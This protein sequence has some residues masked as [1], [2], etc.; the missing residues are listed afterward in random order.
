MSELE[1]TVSSLRRAR[2]GL[3][4][5]R[6]AAD[7]AGGGGV[8]ES[9]SGDTRRSRRISSTRRREMDAEYSRIDAEYRRI[10]ARIQDPV[11]VPPLNADLPTST[12]GI[13]RRDMEA[14]RRLA[15][16]RECAPRNAPMVPSGATPPQ[17]LPATNLG[18]IRNQKAP[19]VVRSTA[20]SPASFA[21][22][23]TGALVDGDDEDTRG[24]L[25][26][27]EPTS[28]DR[29][30]RRARPVRAELLNLRA[31][32]EN[33]QAETQ[34]LMDMIQQVDS[35]QQR[36]ASRPPGTSSTVD[37]DA[38]APVAEQSVQETLRRERVAR[39]RARADQIRGDD[40]EG[41]SVE[42]QAASAPQARRPAFEIAPY[43][44]AA[45]QARRRWGM[46]QPD[47]LSRGEIGSDDDTPSR[48]RRRNR[49]V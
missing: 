45:W 41:T 40:P 31:E 13:L 24:P 12:D 18:V 30:Q 35:N 19:I 3:E 33:A 32:M 25:G 16:I 28:S 5:G 21:P 27:G 10:R 14:R 9:G 1:G 22:S 8:A 44:G 20:P 15:M 23:S 7:S 47:R 26:A 34:A 17:G 39:I 48:R 46:H 49:N 37:T 11:T 2:E 38:A 36:S 6:A 43:G 4:T 42:A 29:P